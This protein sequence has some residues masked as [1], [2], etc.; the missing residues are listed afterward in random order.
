MKYF[1]FK[2]YC[3][4]LIIREN[5]PTKVLIE[6]V[7][8]HILPYL[9]SIQTWKEVLSKRVPILGEGIACNQDPDSLRFITSQVSR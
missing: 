4:T 8:K 9:K 2:I 1:L 5:S 3:N 7:A 6:S